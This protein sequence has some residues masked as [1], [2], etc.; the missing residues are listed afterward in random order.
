MTNLLRFLFRERHLIYKFHAYKYQQINLVNL[1]NFYSNDSRSTKIFVNEVG[2]IIE[3]KNNND[4]DY[5]KFGD[6]SRY[7]DLDNKSSKL[8]STA[9]SR[10]KMYSNKYN[11]DRFGTLNDGDDNLYVI[12]FL[13]LKV[14]L[15]VSE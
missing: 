6:K 3:N 5:V 12:N 7:V 14:N 1:K 8:L 2:N 9:D 13:I 15:A 11:D 4:K 10:T